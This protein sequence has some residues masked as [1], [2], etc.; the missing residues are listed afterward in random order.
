MI[1]ENAKFNLV[2]N[3]TLQSD[4]SNKVKGQ[5]KR[6]SQMDKRTCTGRET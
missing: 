5:T 1:V 6:G 2:V 3:V 4:S